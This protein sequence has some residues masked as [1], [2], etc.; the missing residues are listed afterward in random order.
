MSGDR[1]VIA[2]KGV[3][4]EISSPTQTLPQKGGLCAAFTLAEYEVCET[5]DLDKSSPNEKEMSVKHSTKCAF[6]LAETLI[7]LVIVGIIAAITVPML[8]AKY[9][10]QQTVSAVRNF[11]SDISQAYQNAVT[12]NGSP[13]TWDLNH[14]SGIHILNILEPHLQLIKKC[15]GGHCFPDV[16]YKSLNSN[17]NFRNIYTA[18]DTSSYVNSAIL[19]NG[20]IFFIYTHD[21]ECISKSGTINQLQNIC[22]FIRADINGAK[23]PNQAGKDLFSFYFTK[24]AIIPIGTKFEDDTSNSMNS[25]CSIG[26]SDISNGYSCAAWV[27]E[28]GNMDYLHKEVHW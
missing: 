21:G 8:I 4:S 23:S 1:G 28:K 9:I 11:Y 16:M 3:Q 25:K 7:T 12:E 18:Y 14:N 27:I 5:N 19:N 15:E 24:N 22:G 13:T 17:I 2:R 10:E 6:T 20:T 26:S